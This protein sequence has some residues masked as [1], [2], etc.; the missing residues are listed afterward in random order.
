MVM[1]LMMMTATIFVS[2]FVYRKLLYQSE[3][4]LTFNNYNEA[5]IQFRLYTTFDLQM[6]L[7]QMRYNDKVSN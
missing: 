7:T 4:L 5:G 1:V 3:E 2:H 6:K